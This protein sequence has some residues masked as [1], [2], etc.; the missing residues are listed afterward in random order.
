MSRSGYTDDYGDEDPLAMGRWRAAV[1]SALNGKRG[2]AALRETLAALDAMPQKALI[3]ESLVTPTGEFCTLGVLGAAR[4]LDLSH[5][6]PEDWDAVAAMLGIAPA[7]V[8]EIVW[9]NDEGTSAYE[10]VDVVICGPMPLR[11]FRRPY[12][13]ERHNRTVRIEIDPVIVAQRRWQ[14][15]RNWVAASIKATEATQ[16]D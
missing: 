13:E 3:G 6:D 16:H 4:G 15:M 9:E 14:R 10:Y 1:R 12:S 5:V 7:M 2:Q 11:H 8:R